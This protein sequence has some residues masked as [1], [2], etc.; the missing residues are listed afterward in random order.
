MLEIQKTQKKTCF[1][2][3]TEKTV[4]TLDYE[5]YRSKVI[6]FIKD[7]RGYNPKDKLAKLKMPTFEADFK[8]NV[9]QMSEKISLGFDPTGEGR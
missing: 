6:S 5:P 8:L 4:K 1:Q 9:T 3:T 7:F 2:T